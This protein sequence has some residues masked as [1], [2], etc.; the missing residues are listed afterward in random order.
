M[1]RL[2]RGN[3]KTKRISAF[4]TEGNAPPPKAPFAEKKDDEEE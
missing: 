1:F 2:K 4:Q 3:D